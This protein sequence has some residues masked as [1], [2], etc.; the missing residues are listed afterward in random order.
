MIN[1]RIF[2]ITMMSTFCPYSIRMGMSTRIPPIE[3]GE[4]LD[5][6]TAGA[7]ESIPIG[8]LTTNGAAKA[9]LDMLVAIFTVDVDPFLSQN[10]ELYGILSCREKMSSSCTWPCIVT[11]STFCILGDTRGK[12]REMSKSWKNW[13]RSEQ[14]R[15][16]SSTKLGIQPS[17]FIQLQVIIKWSFY[18]YLYEIANYY[19][20]EHQM[21]GRWEERVF[22]SL[23]L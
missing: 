23:T 1:S 19:F 12:M 2:S 7:M 10:W 17:F 9:L 3:C 13:E 15:Q 4:K 18:R 20:Q 8:I 5:P 11:G 16:V 6:S 21:I 22:G 14:T